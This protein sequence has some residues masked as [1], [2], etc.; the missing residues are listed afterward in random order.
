MLPEIRSILYCTQMGPNAPYVF[1]WAYTLAKR[2]EARVHV[3]YVIEGLTKRQR[4]MVE[5]YS[6][7][8]SLSAIIEKAEAEAAA[9]L[10][11]RLEAFFEKNA[12]DDHWQDFVGELVVGHGHATEEILRHAERTGADL[13]VAGAHRSESFVETIVGSTARRLTERSPVPVLVV[14]VPEGHQDLTQSEE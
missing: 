1:R 2:F 11:R 3:L 5:G 8:D 4:A 13:I 12:P 6:G 10:P 14:R 7:H 9:R